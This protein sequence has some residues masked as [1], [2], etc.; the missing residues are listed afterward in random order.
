VR[1]GNWETVRE[2]G[3]GGQ[4]T[5]YLA[6]DSRVVPL[7][8]ILAELRTTVGQLGAVVQAPD[9]NRRNAMRVLELIDA[10]VNRE[11]P[12]SCG[13]L[14][15]LHEAARRDSKAL[16]RL[17]MELEAL[18][19]VEHPSLLQVLDS[20]VEDGWY[21]TPFYR[22]GTL[23][24]NLG[25][26]AGRP[27]LALDA[28]RQLVQGVAALHT[29]GVV[30]RDIKPEN[31]FLADHGLVLG[32]F[33]IVWFHDTVATRV[34]D[35][36]E[37]VGSR[38]WMPGWA[39][40]MR[41]DDVTPAFD[42]F[43][44][45]KVLWAMISGSAKLRLWYYLDDSFNL[46]RR[47]PNNERMLVINSLLAGCVVERAGDCWPSAAELLKH[48]E[49]VIAQLRRGGQV[50]SLGVRRACAVCG[51]GSYQMTTW[52]KSGGSAI[53]NLGI[54]PAGSVA[55]RFFECAHCGHVQ[56]FRMDRNPPGWV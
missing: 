50:L 27:D 13:A 5:A 35:T 36:Y 30:H 9:S 6:L 11:S 38:D 49:E 8:S 32:D 33:G 47:F 55:Y 24:D 21:V 40:G 2:L 16:A 7:D 31:V 52:E 17:Q 48:V 18:S 4:G 42:V 44:L 12:R 23:A 54:D 56:L 51:V 22:R 25:S 1:L 29:R 15:L 39:M 19:R 26:F 14:K 37:N 43:S 20:S 28:F 45:G 10:Y 3:R 46:A 34:S 53:R 41:V